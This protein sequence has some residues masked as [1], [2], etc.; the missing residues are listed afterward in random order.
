ME[1]DF[2]GAMAIVF[3]RGKPNRFV[4]IHNRCSGNI[5]FPAGKREDFEKSSEETAMREVQ[6]ET[7]LR[8]SECR[9]TRIGIVNEF[10]YGAGKQERSGTA[11]KQ[12]VFLV[13]ASRESLSSEDP[14]AKVLGWFPADEVLERL[15]FDDS[16]DIFRRVL[17]LIRPKT[18]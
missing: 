9:F 1:E 18:L 4:L 6:E 11:A 17:K 15:T 7:G 14:N 3:R 16:R 2:N 10:T 13:E 5:T 12:P 8:P